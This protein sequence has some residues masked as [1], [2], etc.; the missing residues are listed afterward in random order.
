ML[1]FGGEGTSV[2]VDAARKSRSETPL[3]SCKLL[4]DDKS[5]WNA[6]SGF[7]PDPVGDAKLAVVL[8]MLLLI[9]KI[10]FGFSVDVRVIGGNRSECLLM[11]SLLR[12]FCGG[13]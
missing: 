2:V 12:L 7:L 13:V 8:L 3:T 1:F 5:L 11:L 6:T 4:I 9:L 10:P